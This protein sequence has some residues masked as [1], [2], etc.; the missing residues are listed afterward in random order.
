METQAFCRRLRNWRNAEGYTAS[1]DPRSVQTAL[2]C[3]SLDRPD[4]NNSAAFWILNMD[5][6]RNIDSEK[7]ALSTDYVITII[8][9]FTLNIGAKMTS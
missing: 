2:A 9:V 4:W 3:L 5:K 7:K 8:F 6:V 1:P